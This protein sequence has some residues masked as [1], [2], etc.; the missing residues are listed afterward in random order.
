MWKKSARMLAGLIICM[1]L[2]TA[3]QK[4]EDTWVPVRDGVIKI[5][6]LGEES[7]M[8]DNG[9]ME[10]M[11]LAADNFEE[12]TGVRIETVIYD[13]GADY[14]RGI[15]C[16]RE[17]AQDNSISA[18]LV[19]QELDYID[20]TAEIFDEAG[21]PFILTNGCYERTIDQAYE[22]M[23]VDCLNADLAG[24]IMAQYIQEKGYKTIAFCHSD[25]EYEKDELKGLQK[26]LDGSQA[27]LADTVTG[28]YTQ[29]EFNAMY[30][31]W[32]NLGIDAVCISNYDIYNSDLIKMLREKGSD[33]QVI[34]DYVMDTEEEIAVNGSYMEGT[35]IVGM[36][37][38]D[39]D[40][41]N[42]DIM[43]QFEETYGM[44]MSEK[45]IQSYDIISMLG[46]GLNSGIAQSK[47]LI[48][49]MKNHK[50]YEGISGTLRFDEKGCLIP[51][52]DEILT[53]HN[54]VF[55]KE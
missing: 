52:G 16:A 47:Q 26:H 30:R 24:G 50:G 39:S 1:L 38:N 19:K 8:K 23:L 18:V 36:Y 27:Y 32:M 2:T 35:A 6:V 33:L 37:I 7:Y 17:I 48:T 14:N 9:S 53:F 29:E 34:G 4:A 15:A 54:G 12:K 3:C 43:K 11:E 45:A 13:D 42:E 51:N 21:K 40:K 41:T 55:V 49:Y 31:R 5:A 46:E 22:Y 20:A 28:P 25:T 10:A 44:E